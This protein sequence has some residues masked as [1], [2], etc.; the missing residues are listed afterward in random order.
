[1]IM[2]K[3]N[4]EEGL[5]WEVYYQKTASKDFTNIINTGILLAKELLLI[6]KKPVLK[7]SIINLVN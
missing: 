4:V 1:M 6:I 5:E 3:F 2:S 7:G